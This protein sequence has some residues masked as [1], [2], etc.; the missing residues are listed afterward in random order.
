MNLETI[1]I[2][3]DNLN[4]FQAHDLE[5]TIINNGPNEINILEI[6]ASCGCTRPLLIGDYNLGPGEER[7]FNIKLDLYGNIGTFYKSITFNYLELGNQYS[8]DLKISITQK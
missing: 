6:N 7:Q 1:N 5:T 2:I 3:E 4:A 8:K